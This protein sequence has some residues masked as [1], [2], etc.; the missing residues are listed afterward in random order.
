MD[1]NIHI[2]SAVIPFGFDILIRN[3]FQFFQKLIFFFTEQGREQVR[4]F[5]KYFTLSSKLYIEGTNTI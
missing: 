2:G 5:K 4:T 3:F 1:K